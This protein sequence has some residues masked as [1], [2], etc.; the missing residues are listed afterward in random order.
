[1][2]F[3]FDTELR[4]WHGQLVQA[5]PIEKNLNFRP[6]LWSETPILRPLPLLTF[7][8]NT[9]APKPDNIFVGVTLSLYSER[10]VTVLKQAG[11]SFEAFPCTLIDR[12]TKETLPLNYHVVHLLDVHEGVDAQKSD[13]DQEHRIIRKLVLTEDCIK[14]ERSFFR[15][16]DRA[17]LVLIHQSLKSEFERIGIT[18]C[19]YIPIDEYHVGIMP[20]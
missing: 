4:Y 2:Y 6:H 9:K 15:L 11:V 10:L 3:I 17:N 12:K 8:L 20:S 5:L 19:C 18:G 16:K 14:S 7:T 13:I 1:M